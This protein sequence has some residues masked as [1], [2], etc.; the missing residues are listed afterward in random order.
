MSET[1]DDATR[2][3]KNAIFA[4]RAAA[5]QAKSGIPNQTQPASVPNHGYIPGHTLTVERDTVHAPLP[6]MGKVYPEDHPL[7]NKDTVEI[8]E[9]RAS[10]EDILMN[11]SFVKKGTVVTELIKAC[12]TDKRI[13]PLDLV[14]GD[15]NALMIAARITG[16][17]EFYD[18]KLQCPR[19]DKKHKVKVNLTEFPTRDFDGSQVQQVGSNEFRFVLPTGKVVTFKFLTGLDEETILQDME[20]K[21]KK[22][23]LQ[24]NIVTTRLMRSIVSV[25]GITSRDT[26]ARFCQ[27]MSARDSLAL[28][29]HIDETEPA[30]QMSTELT[31]E[32]PDCEFVGK[33]NVPLG[34]S[35]FYPNLATADD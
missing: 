17:T 21:K 2:E 22:G 4:A 27:N 15:R 14:S 31:C 28:R 16:Y 5:E 7:F 9:M 11:R 10:E 33:V 12:L 35:F 1:N 3:Y 20:A 6:S 34:A 26:I 30:I 23:I 8:F 24:E 18:C 32:N 13:N 25:E 29:K 19:C